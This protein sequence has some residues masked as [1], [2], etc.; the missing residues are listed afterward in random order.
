MFTIRP[1]LALAGGLAVLATAALAAPAAAQAAADHHDHAAMTQAPPAQAP[2]A[3]AA[4]KNPALPAPEE[5]AKAVLETSPRHGEWAEVKVAGRE[6]PVKLWVVYP[7]RKD[8]APVV[9][10]ISEI[11]GLSDWIR[12][13]ADQLAK[14]GFIAVAPDFISG[15]GPGGGGTV[16]GRDAA[17]RS[18]R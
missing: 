7:E 17:T 12:G 2:A 9:M 10:V 15:K 1:V 13:V 14:D 18:S 11:F 5:G 3:P 16:G 4:A 6:A 8:K